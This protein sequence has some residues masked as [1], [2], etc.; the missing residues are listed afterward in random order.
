MHF[1]FLLIVM[2]V[3]NHNFTTLNWISVKF[4]ELQ[5]WNVN[6]EQACYS[7]KVEKNNPKSLNMKQNMEMHQQ[8][9]IHNSE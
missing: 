9:R 3:R 6:M 4:W 2:K 8:N 7:L 5:Q 1:P